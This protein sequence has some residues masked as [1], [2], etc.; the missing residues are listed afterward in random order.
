[1]LATLMAISSISFL[2]DWAGRSCLRVGPLDPRPIGPSWV[3]IW[4]AIPSI[5]V[6]SLPMVER[7]CRSVLDSLDDWYAGVGHLLLILVGM[8]G[9]GDPCSLAAADS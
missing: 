2:R 6:L 8:R 5:L 1:M 4:A 9:I 7:I 3:R